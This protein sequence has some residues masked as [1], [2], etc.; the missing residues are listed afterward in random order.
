MRGA[1]DKMNTIKCFG[2]YG[3]RKNRDITPFAP[4]KTR[5]FFYAN[6][7]CNGKTPAMLTSA[8]KT[9]IMI[10]SKEAR[11]CDNIPSARRSRN[12]GKNGI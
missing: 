3:E 7:L 10:K 2:R 8:K 4:A 1:E 6:F 9:D 12:S 5:A 11:Q